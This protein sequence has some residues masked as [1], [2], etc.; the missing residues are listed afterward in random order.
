MHTGSCHCGAVQ[1]EI[2]SAPDHLTNCNC[3]ICWRYGAL[4]AYFVSGTVRITGDRAHFKSYAWG[5]ER[6]RF[7]HCGSC[8]VVTHW[9][10]TTPSATSVVGVNMRNFDIGAIS[11]ARV[12]PVDG[13]AA[14]THSGA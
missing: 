4:W 7:F 11:H 1:L 14:R 8:G 6:L 10:K 12:V 9:E 3:Y 2:P 13:R 5:A